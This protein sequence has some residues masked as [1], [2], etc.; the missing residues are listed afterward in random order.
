MKCK[1]LQDVSTVCLSSLVAAVCKPE[2]LSNVNCPTKGLVHLMT[3]CNCAYIYHL[4]VQH[5]VY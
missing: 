2:L 1:L 3:C 5:R 4:S